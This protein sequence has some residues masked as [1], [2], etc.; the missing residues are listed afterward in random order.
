MLG[1]LAEGAETEPAIDRLALLGCL[2]HSGIG[3]ELAS[4]PQGRPP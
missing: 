2:Q 3:A 4:D 1:H